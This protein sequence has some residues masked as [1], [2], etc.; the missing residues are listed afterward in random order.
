MRSFPGFRSPPRSSRRQSAF[1]VVSITDESFFSLRRPIEELLRSRA[2]P[3]EVTPDTLP[4][5]RYN[6]T[7]PLSIGAQGVGVIGAFLRLDSSTVRRRWAVARAKQTAGSAGHC[8]LA[9]LQVMTVRDSFSS[10]ESTGE[11]R[12]FRPSRQPAVRPVLRTAVR[13]G[14]VYFAQ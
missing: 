8:V 14:A 4:S 3:S 7:R 10:R 13:H 5:E 11:A 2:K 1:G 6:R 9:S 12:F